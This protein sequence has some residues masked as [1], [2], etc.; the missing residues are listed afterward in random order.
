MIIDSISKS[1]EY[2]KM[3]PLFSKAFEFLKSLDFN[4][5]DLK[6]FE[7]DGKNLFVMIS[8]TSMKPS[9]EAKLEVHNDYIDIQMPVSK[10]EKFGWAY[11]NDLKTESAPFDKERDIQFFEDKPSTYF[12]LQP[13]NFVILFPHDAHAP[14][15]GEESIIKIVVKVKVKPQ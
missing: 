15:I 13:G 9:D 7:L 8:D 2:E 4:H 6:K 5:L 1:S 11:R 10:A 12:D 3:H 14:C